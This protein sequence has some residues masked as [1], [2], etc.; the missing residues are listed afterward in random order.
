VEELSLSV[1]I[2]PVVS[3]LTVFVAFLVP[4]GLCF[5][6]NFVGLSNPVLAEQVGVSERF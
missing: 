4:F 3:A 6:I 1:L 5:N 2:C